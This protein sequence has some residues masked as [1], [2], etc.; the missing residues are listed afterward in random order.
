M[1]GSSICRELIGRGYAVK[2]L[3]QKGRSTAT[4]DGLGIE[5]VSGDLLDKDRLIKEMHGCDAVIHIAAS[6]TVWPR[7]SNIINLVNITGTSNVIDAVKACG[8]KRMV[9]IGSASSFTCLS[10]DQPATEESPYAGWK[11]GMDYLDSKYEAQMMLMRENVENSFP[12]II[13]NPTFMIGP[14]DSGPSSGMML[15]SLYQGKIPGYSNGG[16]NFI[17]STDVAKGAVNALT[18][19]RLGECYI[20]GNENLEYK[21]FFKKASYVMGKESKLRRIPD[22]FIYL[23]GFISSVIARTFHK[24]PTLS[25]GMAVMAPMSQYYSPAKAVK[26]LDLPQTPIEQGIKDCMDWFKANKYLD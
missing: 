14:Y 26:E 25:Y 1:L 20:A 16:K 7:R 23:F 17:C 12:V 15:L 2:T 9:H 13:I 22:V 24:K 11:Y 5:I 6:T 3:C 10:K 21:E 4:I 8:L 18:K 19:G